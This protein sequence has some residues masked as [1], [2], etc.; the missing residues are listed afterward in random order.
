MC[1]GL[2]VAGPVCG[3]VKRLTRRSHK[4]EIGG[5]KSPSRNGRS[6][7]IGLRRN[8][9]SIEMRV[10]TPSSCIM[11]VV[12]EVPLILDS[13]LFSHETHV[14]SG[15]LHVSHVIKSIEENVYGMFKSDGFQEQDLEAYRIGGFLFEHAMYEL[16]L[17]DQDIHRIGEVTVDGIV[18]TPDAINLATNRGI[19][20]KMTWRSMKHDVADTMGEFAS[21]HQQM[22]AYG[23]AL[24][25]LCWDLYVYYVCG[26]YGKNRKPK[27][28]H[29]EIEYDIEE[30]E[31][32][33]K[34][35]KNHA[36]WMKQTG[37]TN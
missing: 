14:R 19:E 16:I 18:M 29:F 35:I 37:R 13:K 17:K 28:K 31:G 27:L 22:M 20:T 12:T 7:L 5:F 33:W 1:K 26:D 15:G 34:M 2:T 9:S 3:K 36:A 8:A 11:P 21:W 10:R 23:K 25:V 32:N 6:R 30:V 24:S 4:P